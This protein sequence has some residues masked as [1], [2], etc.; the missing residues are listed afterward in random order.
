VSLF[1]KSEE[2]VAQ[3]ETAKAE[4]ERLQSL[5]AADLAVVLM[6]AFGPEGPRPGSYLNQLQVAMWLMSS[7]PHSTKYLKDLRAPIMEGLQDLENAG[8]IVARSQGGSASLL[9]ATRLG[10]TALAEGTVAEALR[11]PAAP[12]PG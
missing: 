3:E 9:K 6:P 2:K 4:A 12:N 1:G 11:G 10:E 7:Y 8:L 5:S